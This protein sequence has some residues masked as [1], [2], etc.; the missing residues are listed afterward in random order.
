MNTFKSDGRIGHD[1]ASRFSFR[2]DF[3]KVNDEDWLITGDTGATVAQSSTSGFQKGGWATF[4]TGGTDNDEA[5]FTTGSWFKCETNK[6]FALSCRFAVTNAASLAAN[7]C[8]GFINAAAANV[9]IDNG[10]GPIVAADKVLLYK[11]DQGTTM[12]LVTAKTTGT[13]TNVRTSSDVLAFTSSQIYTFDIAYEPSKGTGDIGKFLFWIDGGINGGQ[14]NIVHPVT[15]GTAT[16]S[17]TA[18]PTAQLTPI[19]GIKAGTGAA[20]TL[21]LDY[22]ALYAD[23]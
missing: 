21:H 3:F 22:L 5:Y 8:I 6:K 23:R 11:V 19:I 7:F 14:P 12:N 2:D 18:M 17:I 9:L 10:G 4:T 20:Q 16:S 15:A 13:G 1:Y